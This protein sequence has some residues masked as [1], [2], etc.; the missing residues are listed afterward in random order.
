[1]KTPWVLLGVLDMPPDTLGLERQGVLGQPPQPVK[2]QIAR[3][4]G[5]NKKHRIPET[6][7]LS[8]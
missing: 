6:Q 3:T 5:G 8:T 1:M 2:P 7:T 4:V